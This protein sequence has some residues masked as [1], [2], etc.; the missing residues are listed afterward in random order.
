MLQEVDGDPR[1]PADETTFHLPIA[2]NQRD[3]AFPSMNT[4]VEE[5]S[6]TAFY[7]YYPINHI[8]PNQPAINT[9]PAFRIKPKAARIKIYFL[10]IGI[11]ESRCGIVQYCIVLEVGM[12]LYSKVRE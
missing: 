6:P 2:S 3:A 10:V 9:M 12:V 8:K 1:T 11:D 7:H 5:S 4:R